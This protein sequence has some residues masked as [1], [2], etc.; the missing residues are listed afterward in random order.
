MIVI[1]VLFV[2]VLFINQPK[3]EH[4]KQNS[5]KKVK[6][7]PKMKL[8]KN[9]NEQ[10]VNLGGCRQSTINNPFANFLMYDHLRPACNLNE[11]HVFNNFKDG[12]IIDSRDLFKTRIGYNKFVTLASTQF[13][14]KRDLNYWYPKTKHCKNATRDCVHFT[15]IRYH[16]KM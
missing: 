7:L 5:K 6:Q 3:V 8:I 9:K 10:P 1:L 16:K 13:P 15:D 11:Q 12:L 4:L 14:N 2:L